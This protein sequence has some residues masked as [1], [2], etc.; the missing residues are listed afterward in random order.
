VARKNID[1]VIKKL[2][3][4]G[5]SAEKAK[6]DGVIIRFGHAAHATPEQVK[7][8]REL[9]VTL[10]ANLGSN[11]QTGSIGALDEHPLLY[12][13]YYEVPTILSTDGQGVM[14]TNMQHEYELATKNIREFKRG[15]TSIMIEGNKLKYVDL[16]PEVQKRFDVE[17]LYGSASTYRKDV[18]SGDATDNAR[19][20][21]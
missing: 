20:A 4:M 6:S 5:Y 18:L 12:A 19:R 2:Q 16:P 3:A 15:D 13:L 21:H 10:E 14:Q 9:G 11:L 1:T 17:T 8:M 7:E